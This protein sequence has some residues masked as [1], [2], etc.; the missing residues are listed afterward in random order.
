MYHRS[1]RP[2]K[3]LAAAS[4]CSLWLLAD[5]APCVGQ[6]LTNGGFETPALV[7]GDTGV[8]QVAGFPDCLGAAFGPDGLTLP[9]WEVGTNMVVVVNRGSAYGASPAEGAQFL[10][11]NPGSRAPGG[12]VAQTFQTTPGQAYVFGFFVGDTTSGTGLL[13]NVSVQAAGEASGTLADQAF[14]PPES[15]GFGPLQTLGFTALSSLTRVVFTDV[16]SPDNT[17]NQDLLLDGVTLFAIPEPVS[18]ALVGVA[19]V[20]AVALGH[21]RLARGS[22]NPRDA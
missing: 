19:S 2:I 16:S 7:E 11:F 10:A 8:F 14:S 21:R 9:G 3:T 17:I 22:R 15:A 13:L 5:L 20:V 1:I 4:A 12:N 18:A 6:I